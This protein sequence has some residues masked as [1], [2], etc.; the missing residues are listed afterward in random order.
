MAVK[1]QVTFDSA[2]PAAHATFWAGALGCV[3]QPPPAGFASWEAA[4]DAWGVPAEQRNDRAALVDPAGAGPRLLFQK[5]PEPRTAKNRVHLDLRAAAGLTARTVWPHWRPRARVWSPSARVGSGVSNQTPSQEGSSSCAIRRATSSASTDRAAHAAAVRSKCT[6]GVRPTRARR[7]G[8]KRHPS[9][10]C[11]PSGPIRGL[12]GDRL[13]WLRP[14][15]ADGPPRPARGVSAH[16]PLFAAIHVP[17]QYRQGMAWSDFAVGLAVLFGLAPFYRYLLG[18]LLMDT[19]GS[20]LAIGVQHAAWNAAGNLEAAQG[21][22]QVPA[23]VILLTVV[24]AVARRSGAVQS[25]GAQ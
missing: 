1:F 4:L 21:G 13:G 2:D 16:R 7:P 8:Q 25:R 19:G 24:T 17:L 10:S 23:A 15:P 5:V 12:G 20:I 9:H 14:D 3:L 6:S 18:M 22:W 11:T